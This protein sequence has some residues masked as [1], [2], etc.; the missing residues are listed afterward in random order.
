MYPSWLMTSEAR[1]KNKASMKESYNSGKRVAFWEGKT[2]PEISIQFKEKYSS[3]EMTPIRMLGSS[4]PSW[5]GDNAGY[6]AIHKWLSV[7]FIKSGVC[8]NC[9]KNKKTQ[10]ANISGKYLRITDD[11]LELCRKCHY[12]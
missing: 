11:Y 1:E 3:G 7:H 5:K 8:E 2:R 4:N 9:T 12:W 6:S 10:Y